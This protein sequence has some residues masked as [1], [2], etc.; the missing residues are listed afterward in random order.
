MMATFQRGGCIIRCFPDQQNNANYRV[1]VTDCCGNLIS[2]GKACPCGHYR[3]AVPVLGEYHITVES[4]DEFFPNAA[5]CWACLSPCCRR[6]L[7]FIFVKRP[8]LTAATFTMT[9]QHYQ[10]LPIEKGE[11]NLCPIRSQSSMAQATI[12]Y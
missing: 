1:R 4:S 5:S 6:V 11:L 2:C 12:R 9:D 8:V 7:D 3:F 10:G